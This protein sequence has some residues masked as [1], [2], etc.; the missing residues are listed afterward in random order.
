MNKFIILSVLTLTLSSGIAPM[1]K[2]LPKEP[3]SCQLKIGSSYA[4]GIVVYLNQN[5]GC[6]GL[7]CAP[8][9]QS[10]DILWKDGAA[11][12]KAL[13]LGGYSNWRLPTLDELALMFMSLDEAKMGHFAKGFYWSST[14]C[15]PSFAYAIYFGRPQYGEPKPG[16]F[17]TYGENGRVRAVR[18]F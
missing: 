6:H 13:K 1:P 8:A 14:E 4:G 11:L 5:G 9:D 15:S 12:C 18:T 10:V 3:Q 16:C 17:P 7:V 2:V